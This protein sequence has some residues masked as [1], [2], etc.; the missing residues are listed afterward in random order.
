[1][2]GGCC[3]CAVFLVQG[4]YRGRQ[5]DLLQH[6][7]LCPVPA[8]HVSPP[9]PIIVSVYYNVRGRANAI[10]GSLAPHL[11]P[12]CRSIAA[13]CLITVSTLLGLPNPLNAMQIL[14][15]NIIMDGP[16]AQRYGTAYDDKH[17]ACLLVGQLQLQGS[18][19]ILMLLQ[20]FT[21]YRASWILT[22]HQ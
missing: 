1:M 14:W 8:Q 2:C 10:G 5:D 13:L 16:P 20:I 18:E 22:Q 9:P 4:S 12:L 11:P 7:K 17:S 15:I 19:Q 3:E 21:T 6:H